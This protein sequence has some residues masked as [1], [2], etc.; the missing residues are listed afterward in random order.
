[1][2]DFQQIFDIAADRKGGAEALEGMLSVPKPPKELAAIPDDRWLS[3]MAKCVFQAGF[4]WK[5][6]EAK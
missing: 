5:V 3:M 2:R 6:I 4:S 1:M